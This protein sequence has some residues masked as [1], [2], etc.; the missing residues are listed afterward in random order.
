MLKKQQRPRLVMFVNFKRMKKPII[1]IL[2][3]CFIII[4]LAKYSQNKIYGNVKIK[5]YK[6]SIKKDVKMLL[7]CNFN[8][9]CVKNENNA[10]KFFP[11]LYIYI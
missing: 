5:L 8:R 4:L 6:T 11:L 3:C 7:I 1:D 9:Y 2:V 10:R